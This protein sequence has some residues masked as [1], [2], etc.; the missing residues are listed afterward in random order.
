MKNDAQKQADM[1]AFE[2]EI[3]SLSKE[4]PTHTKKEF[5]FTALERQMLAQQATIAALANQA[6]NIIINEH[7]IRRLGIEPNPSIRVRYAVGLGRLVIF[8]PKEVRNEKK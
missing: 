7:V 8:T 6:Q 4:I 2:R 3:Y 5:T 1:E